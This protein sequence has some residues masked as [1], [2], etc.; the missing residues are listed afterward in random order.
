METE[1]RKVRALERLAAAQERIAD[2]MEMTAA[3]NVFVPSADN[4]ARDIIKTLIFQTG[5]RN[6]DSKIH[7]GKEDEA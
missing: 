2:I 3:T 4:N 7:E 1:A 5:W 6:V